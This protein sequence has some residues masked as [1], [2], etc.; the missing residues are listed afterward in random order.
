M[1]TAATEKYVPRLKKSYH[2]EIVPVL[3]ERFGFKNIMA[4]PKLEKIVV[5]VGLSEARD[6]IKVVETATDEIAAITG[7]KPM[8]CRSKK[9]ISNFR[10]RQGMPI[11]LKVTLRGDRMYEFFDRLVSVSIP[12]IKDFQGLEPRA[13][14]G[15]GN[16]NLGLKEQHIFTEV[17]LEKSDKARGMNITIATSAKKDEHARGLLELMGFPFKKPQKS[18]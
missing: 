2:A 13:F 1:A 5:N 14:D 8:I 11:G 7:Q 15:N 17:N 10:L 9:S 3:M 12:R 18:K 6:E 4:V 16:Y